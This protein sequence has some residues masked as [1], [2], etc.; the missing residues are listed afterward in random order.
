MCGHALSCCISAG[1]STRRKAVAT[2]PDVTIQY[3]AEEKGKAKALAQ[4]TPPHQPIGDVQEA[5]ELE[6]SLLLSRLQAT[7][8]STCKVLATN[9]PEMP[10]G[11]LYLPMASLSSS[12]ARKSLPLL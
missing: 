9:D 5:R 12:D 6:E 7:V 10:G 8:S 1:A 3:T 11:E 2:G 4:E